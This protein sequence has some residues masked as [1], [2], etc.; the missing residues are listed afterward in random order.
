V[1]G[2]SSF[3]KADHADSVKLGKGEVNNRVSGGVEVHCLTGIWIG[4]NLDRLPDLILKIID[5]GSDFDAGNLR[6]Q[7][8]LRA[9]E[10]AARK[11]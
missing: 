9:Q 6:F 5:A 4:P 11:H 3:H 10:A 2:S 1:S 8:G 7:S